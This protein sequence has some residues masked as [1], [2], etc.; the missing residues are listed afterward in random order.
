MQ[1]P[2]LDLLLVD[3][4]DMCVK[5]AELGVLVDVAEHFL[6]RLCGGKRLDQ[7][8][9]ATIFTGASERQS[10]HLLEPRHG[11]LCR[12][13]VAAEIHECDH[14]DMSI[15]VSGSTLEAG[16][17]LVDVH[18]IVHHELHLLPPPIRA[19]I[20]QLRERNGEPEPAAN[21]NACVRFSTWCYRLPGKY[22]LDN[23][24]SKTA[25]PLMADII[26]MAAEVGLKFEMHGDL[27]PAQYLIYV[28]M[29]ADGRCLV[30]GDTQ[31]ILRRG[32][33]D[34]YK[35]GFEYDRDN[36]RM[37]HVSAPSNID[38]LILEAVRDCQDIKVITFFSACDSSDGGSDTEEVEYEDDA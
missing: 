30:E 27:Q 38:D 26:D 23:T 15:A 32:I 16:N 1:A 21:R 14:L 18:T 37:V 28:E 24:D 3:V 13:A 7:K 4:L 11:L 19:V 9:G 6:C 8:A 12:S 17:A 29:D 34:F 22:V 25:A 31:I 20:L 2:L 10:E 33:F 5:V 36:F 35:A